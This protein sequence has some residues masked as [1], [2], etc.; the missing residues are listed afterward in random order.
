MAEKKEIFR[1]NTKIMC[2]ANA[3]VCERLSVTTNMSVRGERRAKGVSVTNC[4]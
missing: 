1:G 3:N 2:K 4:D